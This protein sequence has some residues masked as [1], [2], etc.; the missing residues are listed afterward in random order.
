M[1]MKEPL[2]AEFAMQIGSRQ[3]WRRQFTRAVGAAGAYVQAAFRVGV[4][5]GRWR[6]ITI[7][8]PIALIGVTA[9]DSQEYAL[10]RGTPPKDARSQL[11]GKEQCHSSR[12]VVLQSIRADLC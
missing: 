3:N 4:A 12:P 7:A 1:S 6:L 9:K 11:D 2:N 10:R 5:E 8:W